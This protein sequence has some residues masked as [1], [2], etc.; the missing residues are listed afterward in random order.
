MTYVEYM[1]RLGV[2]VEPEVKPVVEPLSEPFRFQSQLNDYTSSLRRTSSASI[3]RSRRSIALLVSQ[4][5]YAGHTEYYIRMLLAIDR[6]L[7]SRV[8]PV[9]FRYEDR[10]RNY[11]RSISLF[12]ERSLRDASVILTRLIADGPSNSSSAD[13]IEYYRRAL[14]A[15]G[16]ELASRGR[17]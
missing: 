4:P 2:S 5:I 8:D 1:R 13:N 14:L 10:L 3:E 16:A 12:T 6:E 9:P 7:A 15:V 11:T 17:T